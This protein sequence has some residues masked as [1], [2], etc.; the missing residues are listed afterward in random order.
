M[1]M[2]LFLLFPSAVAVD[3]SA[4]PLRLV[5]RGATATFLT[6][7]LAIVPLAGLLGEATEQVSLSGF[8][9]PYMNRPQSEDLID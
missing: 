3:A 8:C 9:F 2:L 6:S 5:S 7:F 4:S 1:L